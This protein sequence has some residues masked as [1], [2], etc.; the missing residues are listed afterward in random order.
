MTSPLLLYTCFHPIVLTCVEAV[1]AEYY[2]NG[3]SILLEIPIFVVLLVALLTL[4][5]P[6]VVTMNLCGDAWSILAS[7]ATFFFGS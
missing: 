3:Y 5:L 2:I 1:F 7:T 6:F 4:M